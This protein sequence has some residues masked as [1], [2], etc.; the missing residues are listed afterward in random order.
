MW[1]NAPMSNEAPLK[2]V[3][4]I[5]SAKKDLAAFPCKITS[6][7][8][9][10]LFLAQKGQ[11]PKSAKPMRI[12]GGSGVQEITESHNGSTYRIVY[13]TR[14]DGYI[15]V[16]HCFEKKSKNGIETPHTEIDMIRARLKKAEDDHSR[17][18]G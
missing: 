14:L 16:L 3:I 10:D 13:T 7:A 15:Y 5:C 9:Y 18:N 2:P 4:W 17:R 12:F 8:G 11:K 1:H 6:A